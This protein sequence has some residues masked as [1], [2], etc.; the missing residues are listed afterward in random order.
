MRI[1]DNFALES[2]PWDISAVD[3]KRAV[4]TLPDIKQLKFI[5]IEPALKAGQHI[6]LI[7]RCYG[8]DV[9]REE[10]Y[11]ICHDYPG[12]AEIRV[13][14]KNGT[15]IRK[16]PD[17]N[18][19]LSSLRQPHY[20]AVSKAS[21][22][23]YLSDWDTSSVRCISVDGSLVFSYQ[24]ADLRYPRTVLADEEGNILVCGQ[25]SCNIHKVTC[26]GQRHSV[27]HRIQGRRDNDCMS[28]AYKMTNCTIVIGLWESD[29][30]LVLQLAR[31]D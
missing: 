25:R 29:N 2:G 5:Y 26:T 17:V 10:I 9:V 18:N 21:S 15:Y 24:H 19:T 6:Q 30:L 14:D 12:N 4:V 13:F 3:S 23:I 8:V 1:T 20:L 28:L 11:V 16:V 22:K 7:K 27:L 31:S